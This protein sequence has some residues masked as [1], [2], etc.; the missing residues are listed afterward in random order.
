MDILCSIFLL[1][2]NL[3]SEQC[4]YGVRVNAK[5]C[6][7]WCHL[8]S[9]VEAK[10]TLEIWRNILL[11]WQ[12]HRF[13]AFCHQHALLLSCQIY[14]RGCWSYD[15]KT[16]YKFSS[17]KKWLTFTSV[18]ARR[19]SHLCLLKLRDNCI[20]LGLDWTRWN[21]TVECGSECQWN[22][23]GFDWLIGA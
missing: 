14:T 22:E 1:R 13:C 18:K 11:S 16:A 10:E 9:T 19:H 6:E 21:D 3:I 15:H 8:I 4:T 12:Q 17:G 2:G 20:G 5:E 7:T 23:S